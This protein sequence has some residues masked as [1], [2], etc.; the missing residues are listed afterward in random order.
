M[1][2]FHK[3]A[4]LLVLAAAIPIGT[5][6]FVV[7][8]ENQRALETEVRAR[9]DETARHAASVVAGDVEGRARQLQKTAAMIH[10][11][12]LSP[13]ELDGALALLRRQAGAAVA[14]F[15]PSAKEASPVESAAP[16]MAP[17]ARG[18]EEKAPRARAIREGAGAVVF[19]PPFDAPNLGPILAGA[20]SV[21]GGLVLVALPLAPLASHLA[22]VRGASG[23]A[24]SLVDDRGRL[25][26]ATAGAPAIGRSVLAAAQT[27]SDGHARRF[28]DEGAPPTLAAFAPV[29]GLG[30]S[31]VVEEEAERAFA[32][33]L[34]MRRLTLAITFAATLLALVLA[35]GFARR[36]SGA[37]ERLAETARAF[38]RGELSA[39]VR[40]G[41][42]ERTSGGDEVAALQRTF[43][44][45]GDKL[46]ESRGEIERWNRELE[47]RVE[48]RT[49]E[50]KE[51]QAQLVQ[52]QKLAALG[53]LGAGVAHEIN[54][55]LG[56]VLG[57]VQ[58]LLADK[59][60]ADPDYEDLRCIDEAARRASQVVQNL[61]RFSVQH[62]DP[63]RTT[64]DLNKLVSGTLSLTRT[65]L[66]EQKIALEVALEEPAPRARG[67]AG[68]L[69]QVL[70]NLVSNARTAMPS[71]GAL[72]VRTRVAGAEVALSVEDTGRGIAPEL[73]EKIFE[74]FFTTK[75]D[76]SNVGLGLSVSYRIISEH[77]GRIEVFSEVGRGSRFTVYLPS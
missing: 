34:K 43:N 58:L 19:A 56:G 63:V 73:R 75:D 22:E 30:W 35:F 6:G 55:P 13:A 4:I 32:A 54:N 61:L 29:G 77:G 57:H 5:V 65:L 52:A 28:V 20:L 69:G 49:R 41:E 42:L 36:L 47:S 62:Q 31:L 27:G 33:P 45:M 46:A 74:P 53:Q 68:Q 23:P 11:S 17:L 38:G 21:P 44:A 25:V 14:G 2:L 64:V 37:L 18:L 72:T 8:R 15:F 59:T 71:G 10:W 50:L 12:A 26:V 48:T 16:G 70:L 76:W 9:F 24:L 40:L 67:D 60:A 51:A 39:R 1:R 3:I 66:A 7:V